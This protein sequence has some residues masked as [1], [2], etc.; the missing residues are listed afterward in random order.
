M[1]VSPTTFRCQRVIAV[2]VWQSPGNGAGEYLTGVRF[3]CDLNP[4]DLE[5]YVLMA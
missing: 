1:L 4:V 2:V 3:R 5:E